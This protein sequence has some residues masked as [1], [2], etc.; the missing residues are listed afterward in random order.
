LSRNVSKL[1]I[2]SR[3]R[4]AVNAALSEISSSISP[5]A[6]QKV[7]WLQC[8]MADWKG[9]AETSK[10]IAKETDRVDILINDAARGIMTY[11]LTDYG[12]DRH[13]QSTP[14]PEKLF[15]FPLSTPELRAVLGATEVFHSMWDSCS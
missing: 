3:A 7:T 9:V 14:L 10:K 12:V 5:E 1:F 15:F 8:D 6:S 11:Q 2:I 13:S 4:D